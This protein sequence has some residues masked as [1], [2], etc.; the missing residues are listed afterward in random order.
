MS[1]K[2]VVPVQVVRWMTRVQEGAY[3][4]YA[5]KTV[6]NLA[7]QDQG[8]AYRRFPGGRV[9]YDLADLDAW[10]MQQEKKAA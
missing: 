7:S 10:V 4:G 8:P 9:L 5:P 3:T 1:E 6:A 2:N